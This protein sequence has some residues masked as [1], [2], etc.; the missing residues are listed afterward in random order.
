MT[1]YYGLYGDNKYTNSIPFYCISHNRNLIDAYNDYVDQLDQLVSSDGNIQIDHMSTIKD[2]RTEEATKDDYDVSEFNNSCCENIINLVH[3]EFNYDTS[4]NKDDEISMECLSNAEKMSNDTNTNTYLWNTNTHWIKP[5]YL[6][7]DVYSNFPCIYP[8]FN[9]INIENN[10]NFNFNFDNENNN[11]NNFNEISK[12]FYE[13]FE[14]DLN[15]IKT[16]GL[17]KITISQI[18]DLKDFFIKI[19]K[20]YKDFDTDFLK[21]NQLFENSSNNGSKS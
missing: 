11:K 12:L 21:L 4:L 14:N 16:K 3:P 2:Y 20:N 5:K 1:D 8:E 13:Y 9:F 18:K 17:S 19:L 6:D 7:D 15:Q 10:H